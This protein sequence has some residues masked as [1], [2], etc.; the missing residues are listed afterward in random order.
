[1]GWVLDHAGLVT[2]ALFVAALLLYGIVLG[3][4]PLRARAL[5]R[6]P[7][8]ATHTVRVMVDAGDP[9]ALAA[10]LA[11][12]RVLTSHGR[13]SPA[14]PSYHVQTTVAVAAD[15]VPRLRETVLRSTS[16]HLRRNRAAAEA[17]LGDYVASLGEQLG[18][19]G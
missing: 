9:A 17:R 5:R 18:R 7:C 4:P 10:A 14:P 8:L 6:L 12:L 11:E 2:P 15:G 13:W 19:E 1:M 16:Y 3:V